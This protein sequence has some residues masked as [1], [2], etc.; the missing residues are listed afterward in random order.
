MNEAESTIQSI[1][2]AAAMLTY[3]YVLC[4]QVE[5]GGDDSPKLGK[6]PHL[7]GGKSAI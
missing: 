3:H 4:D 1:F 2:T 7:E 6:E 5:S